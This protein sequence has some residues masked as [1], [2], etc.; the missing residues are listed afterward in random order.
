MSPLSQQFDAV[1]H[2]YKKTLDQSITISGEQGEYF[3]EV[4]ARHLATIVGSE[5]EGKV[6]DFGCGIG[7]LSHFL[8][9]QLPFSTL[10]GYD[11]SEMSIEKIRS[12]CCSPR[13]VYL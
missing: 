3:A 12:D 9:Q 13:K 8:L 10:H 1:A 7:M 5:F 6:L 11:I 4:K 2:T